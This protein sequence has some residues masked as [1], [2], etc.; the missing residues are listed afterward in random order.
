MHAKQAL[1][2]REAAAPGEHAHKQAHMFNSQIS[3][4]NSSVGCT[5][6]LPEAQ[7][8]HRMHANTIPYIRHKCK[9]L[10]RCYS[11]Q[12]VLQI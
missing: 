3:M 8:M 10:L 4:Q 12:Q 1:E 11:Q 7:Y 9:T 2:L 5:W 6:L